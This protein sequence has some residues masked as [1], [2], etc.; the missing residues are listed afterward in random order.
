LGPQVRPEQHGLAAPQVALAA[1]QVVLAELEP[2][3]EPPLEALLLVLLAATQVPAGPQISFAQQGAPLAHA[4]PAGSQVLELEPPEDEPPELLPDE[5]DDEEPRA[6][7]VPWTHSP[8][9][10]RIPQPPQF[11][12]SVEAC[13]QAVPQSRFGDGQALAPELPPEELPP[14]DG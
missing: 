11:F 12:G 2:P 10:Q 6:M 3:D 13:T 4:A 7:H 8:V 9:G 5:E 1:P 14:L